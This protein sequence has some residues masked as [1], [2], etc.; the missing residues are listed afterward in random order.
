VKNMQFEDARFSELPRKKLAK[1]IR[2]VIR[3]ELTDLQRYT[4]V[5]YYFE[6]RTLVQ[7]AEERCVNKSTICRTLKRAEDKLCRFL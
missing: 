1:Q 3:E 4:L 2:T 6:N 7:I 5:A